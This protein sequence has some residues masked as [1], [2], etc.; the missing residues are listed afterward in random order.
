MLVRDDT[1]LIQLNFSFLSFKIL[2]RDAFSKRPSIKSGL[3]R[4]YS[5]VNKERTKIIQH[6]IRLI[7][8]LFRAYQ[9]GETD[10]QARSKYNYY[11]REVVNFLLY[12]GL[13]PKSNSFKRRIN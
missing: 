5:V 9:I 3:Q 2:F 10:Q 12:N 7:N 8:M 13:R 1:I 11:L 6:L 4:V